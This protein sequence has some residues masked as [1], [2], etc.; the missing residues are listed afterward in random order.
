M[1]FSQGMDC[2]IGARRENLLVDADLGRGKPM[3][4]SIQAMGA[5]DETTELVSLA[6]R[7]HSNPPRG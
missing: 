7:R 3:A 2:L 4:A 5:R 6:E 1:G